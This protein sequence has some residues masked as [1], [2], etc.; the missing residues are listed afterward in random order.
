M[1]VLLWGTSAKTDDWALIHYY[2]P[3]GEASLRGAFKNF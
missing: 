1:Y 2:Q 3:L